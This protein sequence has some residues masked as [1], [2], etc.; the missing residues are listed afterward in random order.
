V[1]GSHCFAGAGERVNPLVLD[2]PVNGRSFRAYVEQKLAPTLRAGDIVV[3]DNLGSHKVN[4]VREN[5]PAT[6][7]EH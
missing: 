4:G 1:G 2:R 6:S 5:H 3:A 7:R